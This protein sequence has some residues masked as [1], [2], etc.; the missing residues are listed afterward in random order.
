M[1]HNH[2]CMA[3]TETHIRIQNFVH[4]MLQESDSPRIVP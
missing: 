1:M 4:K 3:Q 2:L